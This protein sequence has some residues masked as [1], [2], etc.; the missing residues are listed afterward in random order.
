MHNPNLTILRSYDWN[1]GVICSRRVE[2]KAFDRCVR[3]TLW[4][5]RAR[6]HYSPFVSSNINCCAPDTRSAAIPRVNSR[7]AA[8]RENRW[9]RIP[10]WM[11]VRTLLAT[12]SSRLSSF[13]LVLCSMH[14]LLHN[15]I[16]WYHDLQS[17]HFSRGVIHWMDR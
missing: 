14:A 3:E 4:Q 9:K 5:T 8:T 16:Q 7:H 1:Y 10:R 13:D 17:R 6:A 2:I 12:S 11:N 15:K